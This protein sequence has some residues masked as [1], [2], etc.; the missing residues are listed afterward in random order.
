MVETE[1]DMQAV[2]H[3]LAQGEVLEA[4]EEPAVAKHTVELITAVDHRTHH[5]PIL[6]P[7][8][9]HTVL[10]GQHTQA[11]LHIVAVDQIMHRQAVPLPVDI[12]LDTLT[13]HHPA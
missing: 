6:Q 9:L 11:V 13:S 10:P 12:K 4:M 3:M 2:E 5:H 8:D 7:E 1:V